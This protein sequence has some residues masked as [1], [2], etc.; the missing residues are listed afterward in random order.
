MRA[1]QPDTVRTQDYLGTFD[2]GDH[3]DHHAASYFA[4]AAHLSYGTSHTFIGYLDYASENNPQNVFNSDLTTKTNAFYAYL[5]FDS[6]PCGDPPPNCGNDEYSLWLK[7]QYTVGT[8]SGGGPDTTP[9]AVSSVAPSD[10]TTNALPNAPV[11]A[12]FSEAVDPATVTGTTFAVVGP[13]GNRIGASVTTSG[14][15]VS[16]QPTA[17][18]ALSTT[19]VAT[20][21]SGSSGIKDLAGNPLGSDYTWSFTTGAPDL[22]PPTTTLTFP[23]AG[24]AYNSAGWAGGCS[25]AGLCGTAADSG[26][27]VQSVQV[28]V[29]R[30]STNRYWTESTFGSTTERWVT[31]TGTTA[32][33][34]GPGTL[35]G[36]G[37]YTVR[38]RATDAVGNV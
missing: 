7:R 33:T 18:L 19:Y 23:G 14:S 38:V 5:Q 11:S 16:L 36:A 17:Q 12:T 3:D 26:S 22:V 6:A 35:P 15:T 1:L 34:S 27:G 9:P 24:G 13:D 28:S 25:P 8:E 10:G 29:Y 37:S 2:D 20:L 30:A 4:Q 32:W 31:A 21:T